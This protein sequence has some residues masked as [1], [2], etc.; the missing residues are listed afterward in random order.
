ME[1]K[2]KT[3][4]L[5]IGIFLISVLVRL[6]HLDRPLS[7]HHEFCTAIVLIPLQNWAENG[8]S[9][10]HYSPSITFE[11]TANHHIENLT[12]YPVEAD[13]R[14]YYLSHPPFAYVLP[15]FC[16]QIFGIYPTPLALQVFNLLFHL[17]S[18]LL[19]YKI[20]R[21][22]T[23]ETSQKV[24]FGALASFLVYLFAPATLWFHGNAYMS[25]MFIS[26]ILILG[27]WVTLKAFLRKE[28]TAM[29]DTSKVS[30]ILQ[31]SSIGIVVFLMI[32]TEWLGN[33]F[34]FSVFVLA[35]IK[36]FSRKEKTAMSD[37]SK[38]SDISLSRRGYWLAI[39]G[40]CVLGV[41][42]GLGLTFWQYSSI[43]GFETYRAYFLHRFGARSGA[44]FSDNGVFYFL[45][46][47]G[48][49]M[50]RI[51]KH[52]ATGFLPVL[53]FGAALW[54][55]FIYGTKKIF[56]PTNT[57]TRYFWWLAG[58]PILMHHLVFV[59]FTVVHD[60]A[61]LKGGI[62]LA[63]GIGLLVDK[64]TRHHK[65]PLAVSTPQPPPKGEIFRAAKN[66][67]RMYLPLWRGLGGGLLVAILLCIAQYY[68]INR[69]GKISQNGDSYDYMQI[70][71]ENIRENAATDE[72]IFLNGY[73]P[74]PQVMYYARRNMLRAADASE[75]KAIL[76]KRGA[77]RG[78]L[79]TIKNYKIKN[80]EKVKTNN[81]SRINE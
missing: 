25:D 52:Y 17:L 15:Y 59:E 33:F 57:A 38:V 70:L 80:I 41:V 72:V 39:A 24:H 50:L 77:E 12:A 37:T 67:S 23:K 73:K 21:I 63:V 61:A 18:C 53:V 58:F 65:S 30:N 4:L 54:G 14:Y 35:L 26:N 48:K 3:Y 68:Y 66:L 22:I 43:A 31:V 75:V 36:A 20:V 81:E 79:F 8:A 11:G 64:L 71:G 69:P 19:I 55:V 2:L 10:Y 74:D 34:A 76:E 46:K 16:F 62:L 45:W 32:Y 51:A 6:P 9:I 47:Y 49:M 44:Q 28:K 42:A 7:K 5:L 78:V 13:G 60:F 40:A 27:I 56:Q 1:N 29:S